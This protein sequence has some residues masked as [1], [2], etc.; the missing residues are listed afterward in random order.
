MK[1][2]IVG[3]MCNSACACIMA[4]HQWWPLAAFNLAVAWGCMALVLWEERA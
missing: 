1:F 4:A 3:I 2:S